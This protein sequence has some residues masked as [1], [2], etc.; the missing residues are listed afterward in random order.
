MVAKELGRKW[1][2]PL[3]LPMWMVYIVSAALEKIAAI[4]GTTSTLNRD[5][6]KIMRQRNWSCDV[7]EAVADFGFHADYPLPRGVHETVKTYLAEK[8]KK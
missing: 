1:V 4:R 3:K 6:F 5:K 7:S 8:N 2:L